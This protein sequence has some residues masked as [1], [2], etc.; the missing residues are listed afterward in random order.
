MLT[1][2]LRYRGCTAVSLTDAITKLATPN[3]HVARAVSFDADTAP[4]ASRQTRSE[5]PLSISLPAGRSS[6]SGMLD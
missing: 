2:S 6:C 4:P 3:R 5:I 1:G